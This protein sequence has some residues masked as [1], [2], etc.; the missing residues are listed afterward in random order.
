MKSI[1]FS[2]D[3]FLCEIQTFGK[4]WRIQLLLSENHWLFDGYLKFVGNSM[5]IEFKVSSPQ[6][7]QRSLVGALRSVV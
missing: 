2:V 3:R 6:S 5:D 4:H 1:T 7:H